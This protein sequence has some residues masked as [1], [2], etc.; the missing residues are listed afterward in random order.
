MASKKMWVS[1]R[2]WK[3]LEKKVAGL[4]GK[5]Q[6]QQIV[7]ELL[8]EFSKS[9]AY[10]EGRDLLSYQQFHSPSANSSKKI[11]VL[12]QEILKLC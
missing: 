1:K 11:F 10:S 2:R 4:E 7:I 3:A 5:V 9:V 12:I 8:I 6:S